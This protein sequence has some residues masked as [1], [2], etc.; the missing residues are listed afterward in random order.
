MSMKANRL[1]VC[2]TGSGYPMLYHLD[3][4]GMIKW[5]RWD[6]V[7]WVGMRWDE[8]GWSAM[9]WDEVGWGGMECDGV[10]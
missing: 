5:E 9:G 4:R 1:Y 7:G 6:G 3:V 8:V 10:G 2:S